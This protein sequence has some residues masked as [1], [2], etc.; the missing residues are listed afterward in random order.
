[1][2]GHA[3]MHYQV[4]RRVLNISDQRIKLHTFYCDRFASARYWHQHRRLLLN[5]G[6]R[7]ADVAEIN[8]TI[9][10]N[11]VSRAAHSPSKSSFTRNAIHGGDRL[12]KRHEN[13]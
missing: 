1:M 5:Q 12:S 4:T 13:R 11:T 10:R 9:R 3:V 2:P 7:N 8:V 6:K